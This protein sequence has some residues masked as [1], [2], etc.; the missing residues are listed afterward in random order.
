M[1]KSQAVHAPVQILLLERYGWVPNNPRL[2][3]QSYCS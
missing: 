3:Y 2:P 1:V